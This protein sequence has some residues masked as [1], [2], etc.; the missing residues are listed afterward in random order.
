MFIVV[1]SRIRGRRKSSGPLGPVLL[2]RHAAG[3]SVTVRNGSRIRAAVSGD[4]A[5]ATDIRIA[6]AGC[7]E[8]EHSQVDVGPRSVEYQST[9]RARAEDS[10]ICMQRSPTS[11]T[12]IDTLQIQLE[13]LA[14]ARGRSGRGRHGLGALSGRESAGVDL[15]APGR[16]HGLCRKN[17]G[18]STVC[19]RRWHVQFAPGSK[20]SDVKEPYPSKA[21]LV[22]AIE[23]GH[24]R[25]A[26]AAASATEEAM[27]QP[28][29]VE[30]LKP[31]VL[32]TTGDVLAHLMC[33]HAAFHT[34]QLFCL[35]PQ[36]RQGVHHLKRGTAWHSTNPA[37]G[38]GRATASEH[39]IGTRGQHPAAVSP[40]FQLTDLIDF[41]F[42]SAILIAFDGQA[43]AVRRRTI[44]SKLEPGLSFRR[45][46]LLPAHE[47]QQRVRRI[48]PGVP[49]LSASA[50]AHGRLRTQRFT[51]EL[52]VIEWDLN[53]DNIFFLD[54]IQWGFTAVPEPSTIVLSGM[55]L[56]IVVYVGLRRKAGSCRRLAS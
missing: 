48:R 55:G 50:G 5:R 53:N 19:P 3:G 14:A 46:T 34:A 37:Y 27:N 22:T 10:R 49:R 18:A 7:K 13:L 11:P 38:S 28:H 4:T 20:P 12:R 35:P 23:N 42:P 8:I 43:E 44:G 2:L 36:D 51:V 26:E 39:P 16:G 1:F 25:V 6:G 30:L 31:I 17:A 56:A 41:T 45:S 24:R 40:V 33:T 54:G 32:K 52:S 47:R 9:P 15:G 29:S 21:E